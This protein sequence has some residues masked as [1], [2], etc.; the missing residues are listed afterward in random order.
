MSKPLTGSKRFCSPQSIEDLQR[1]DF[2][3]NKSW[4][5]VCDYIQNSK[6]QHRILNKKMKRLGQKVKNLQSLLSY[7]K[8]SGLL[9]NEIC[10]AL[11]MS[12]NFA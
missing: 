6:K 9:S 11:D 2:T 8:E 4:Q 3:S 7:V 1:E 10:K 12:C 5:I